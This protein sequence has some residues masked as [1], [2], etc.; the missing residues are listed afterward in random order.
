MSDKIKKMAVVG[1]HQTD[2]ELQNM[3]W[4]TPNGKKKKD[5]VETHCYRQFKRKRRGRLGEQGTRQTGVKDHHHSSVGLKDLL[6]LIVYIAV[7]YDL[8]R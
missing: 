6:N 8:V 2:R 4:P 3:R 1:T 7:F 5:E